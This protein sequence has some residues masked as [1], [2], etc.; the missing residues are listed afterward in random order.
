MVQQLQGE[1][2]N[3]PRNT[4][5]VPC[6]VSSGLNKEE[7][8]SDQNIVLTCNNSEENRQQHR[9]GSDLRVLNTVYVLNK[10]GNALM[11]TC[12]SRARR[13]LNNGKAVVV[14]RYPFTIHLTVVTG[15]TKQEIVLGID[16]GYQKVG[17]SAIS[18]K[19]ELFSA[20]VSLRN[21]IVKLNS[22]RRMYRRNRRNRNHWYRPSRFNNRK[23][24]TGWLAP[25]I[26]HKVNSYLLV[27][28]V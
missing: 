22:E 26:Q 18:N 5:L 28:I 8:L 6:S 14:K 11:P 19:Q 27:C 24:S 16:I 3:T 15:E 23:K 20:E 25:S 12:Q 1:F 13:L 21:N 2:K 10:R 17:I 9:A 4:S 7:T